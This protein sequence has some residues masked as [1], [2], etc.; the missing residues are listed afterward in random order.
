MAS[1]CVWLLIRPLARLLVAW[2][3]PILSWQLIRILPLIWELILSSTWLLVRI[4]P[5]VRRL[6][7]LT[8]KLVWILHGILSR[9]C[10]GLILSR[11]LI[12]LPVRTR[13]LV[14]T[15]LW[16]QSGIWVLHGILSSIRIDLLAWI[17]PLVW[18]LYILTWKL[19]RILQRILS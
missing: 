8:G 4:R 2:K 17:R 11:P 9:S 10:L 15:L 14:W 1:I 5:L 3:L 7:I 16:I 6:S 19:G 13:E 12:R 18:L